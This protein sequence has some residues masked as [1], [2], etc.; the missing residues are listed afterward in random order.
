MKFIFKRLGYYIIAFIGAITL[1]F[2][3]PRMM[4]GNPVQAYVASLYQSGGNVSA[5]VIAAVEKMFGFDQ[6]VPLFT[7]FINYI[8]G[9]LQGDWGYSFSRYPDT[10]LTVIGDSIGWT[11]FL[12]GMTLIIANVI[13]IL[14]GIYVAWKRGTKRDTF[15]TL[16][17]QVMTNIPTIII[18][19]GLS[20]ALAYTDIFPRGY[21]VTHLLDHA[22]TWEYIKDVL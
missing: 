17:G 5:E 4:P 2:F 16:T 18:A 11:I 15:I 3:L 1:N 19:F 14:L 6:D 21:A 10:V 9:I 13:N 12:M 8:K 7:S 22:N 20:F